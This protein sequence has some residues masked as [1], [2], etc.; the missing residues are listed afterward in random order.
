LASIIIR[1]VVISFGSVDRY[2]TYFRALFLD[3]P[4]VNPGRRFLETHQEGYGVKKAVIVMGVAVALAGCDSP[5][6]NVDVSH[7]FEALAPSSAVFKD[8]GDVSL[9]EI[10]CSTSNDNAYACAA[11]ATAGSER[12]K[13]QMLM[14]K[15]G[16]VW[17]AEMLTE[18]T[19]AS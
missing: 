10:Y 6:T 1:R 5:P 7:A 16:G 18:P 2:P 11:M 13:V 4:Y 19:P 8:A 12:Y 15:D 17:K 14:T 9:S 3:H